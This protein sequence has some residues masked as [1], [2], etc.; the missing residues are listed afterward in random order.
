MPAQ[1]IFDGYT[2][3]HVIPARRGWPA[4]TFRYRPALPEAVYDYL[5]APSLTGKQRLDAAV[6]LLAAHVVSWDLTDAK[7]ESTP[8]TP[9]NL[10]RVPYPVIQGFLDAVTSYGP[11]QQAADLGN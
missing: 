4:V 10:R 8:V 1:L 7:G 3:D 2:W 6:K 9:E 5:A 11:E